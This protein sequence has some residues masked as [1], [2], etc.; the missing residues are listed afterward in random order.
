MASGTAPPSTPLVP[1][2]L[3]RL[4]ERLRFGDGPLFP[5]SPEQRRLAV[6][7][8]EVIEFGGPKP[9]EDARVG[10]R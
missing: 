5:L 3:Q 2:L 9:G 8:L 4:D 6:L 10:R 7:A 1:Q